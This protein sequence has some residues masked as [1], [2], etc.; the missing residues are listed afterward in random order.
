MFTELI[1]LQK[2]NPL[3]VRNKKNDELHF[4]GKRKEMQTFIVYEICK[5][6][7]ADNIC[8]KLKLN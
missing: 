5:I 3:R 7:K 8:R 4:F 2:E 1:N 6:S